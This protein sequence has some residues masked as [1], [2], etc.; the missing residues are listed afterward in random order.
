MSDL[1]IS[2][3]GL[4]DLGQLLQR[5]ETTGAL[6]IWRNGQVTAVTLPAGLDTSATFIGINDAGQ[7][8]GNAQTGPFIMTP[9]RGC[10]A[11]E[12][13]QVGLVAS[14]FYLSPN[15]GRYIQKIVI[16]NNG[17]SVLSSPLSIV[18]D[19]L[20][21][22]VSVFGINGTTLCGKVGSPYIS[23]AV[24]L[25]PGTSTSIVAQFIDESGSPITYTDRVIAGAGGR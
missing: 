1:G 10:A 9:R 4:N 5:S 22:N 14:A 20:P 8:A 6:E 18:F 13:S 25:E 11:D 3:T 12:T 15:T 2:G 19:A 21:S 24:A 16:T 17:S 23:A 7:I